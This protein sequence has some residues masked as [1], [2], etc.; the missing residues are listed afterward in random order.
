MRIY[1]IT[2]I[3]RAEASTP[4]YRASDAMM[5]LYYLR[6]RNNGTASDEMIANS[7]F[8]GDLNR[9]KVA[10]AVAKRAGAI[11]LVA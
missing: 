3:G 2:D 8:S 10:I 11:R 6:K 4:K 1:A 7:K 5:V 9:A